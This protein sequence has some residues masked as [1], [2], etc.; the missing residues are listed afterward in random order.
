[1]LSRTTRSANGKIILPFSSVLNCFSGKRYYA[2]RYSLRKPA[3]ATP[4]PEGSVSLIAYEDDR[5]E[6][7][8]YPEIDPETHTW[9]EHRRKRRQAILD[10][11]KRVQEQPNVESKTVEINLSR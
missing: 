10:F 1:M 5:S 9:S 8:E 4:H 2:K 7:P 3:Y 11:H 6:Q